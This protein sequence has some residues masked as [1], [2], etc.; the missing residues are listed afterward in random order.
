[1]AARAFYDT[2]IFVTAAGRNPDAAERRACAALLEI[3]QVRWEIALS[4]ISRAEATIREFLDA[5]EIR[6]AAQGVPWIEV[7]MNEINAAM[8]QFPAFKRRL[9]QAGVQSR[10]LKQI[11]AAL[12]ASAQVLIARDQDFFDPRGKSQ[13]RSRGRVVADLVQEEL[14]L[15]VLRPDE[16]L[17]KLR[18]AA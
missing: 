17:R 12:S 2:N 13:K 10:D 6:C 7:K 5:L 16:A 11:F 15:E 1:M 14:G 3:E 9:S 8:R 18:A 4:E